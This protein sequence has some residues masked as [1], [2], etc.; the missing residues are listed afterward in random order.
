MCEDDCT[1][2][3]HVQ[4]DR[5]KFG[6]LKTDPIENVPGVS[7]I[8]FNA[9]FKVCDWRDFFGEGKLYEHVPL[10]VRIMKETVFIFILR[11]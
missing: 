2:L 11:R 7:F 4:H 1:F 3:F 8:K 6:E 9:D 10:I 5:W